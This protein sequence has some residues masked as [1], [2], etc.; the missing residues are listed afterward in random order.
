MKDAIG[1][2]ARLLRC[3][4]PTAQGHCDAFAATIDVDQLDFRFGESRCEGA[5]QATDNPG[6]NDGNPVSGTRRGVPY[7]VDRRFHI[8]RKGRAPVRN[9]LGNLDDGILRDHETI[10]MGMK[11]KYTMSKIFGGTVLDD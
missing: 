11:A 9:I 3:C 7:P 6:P 5:D 10:L 1:F 8:G 4:K 2:A